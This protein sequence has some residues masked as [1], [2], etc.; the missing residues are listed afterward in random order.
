MNNKRKYYN[1][2]SFYY[3]RDVAKLMNIK[4]LVLEKNIL[5][6]CI[7]FKSYIYA[8]MFFKRKHHKK[9]KRKNWESRLTNGYKNRLSKEQNASIVKQVLEKTR[10][11]IYAS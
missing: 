3:F 6:L 1:G 4:N 8:F 11:F 9:N 5:Y 7:T 2:V 10:L